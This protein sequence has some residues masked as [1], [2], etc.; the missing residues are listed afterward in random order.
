M[1]EIIKDYMEQSGFAVKME[2]A[3]ESVPHQR[4]YAAINIEGSED[5]LNEIMIVPDD[6]NEIEDYSLVQSFVVF[7]FEL[8]KLNEDQIADIDDFIQR[9]NFISPLGHFG[10]ELTEGVVYYKHVSF[11]EKQ[12]GTN[13]L[14]KLIESFW[15]SHYLLN[16]YFDL[17]ASMVSGERSFDEIM[18]LL[19]QS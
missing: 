4:I 10:I 6:G 15:L 5:L 11:L 17:F 1:L 3:D 2:A 7:P 9:I 16:T 12:P 19:S 18:E 14:K 13:E 8:F